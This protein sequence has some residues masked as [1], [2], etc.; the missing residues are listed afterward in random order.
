ME[1]L[2]QTPSQTVGPFFAYSLT[3]E[4]YGYDYNS[5]ING[6]LINHDT[7]GERI[8]ITGRIY[9]GK[10]QTIPDALIELWQADANGQY[11]SLPIHQKN[12]GFTGLGRLGTGTDVQDRF[13]FT[14]IK[15]GSIG[16]GQA[17]HINIILFMRG[18][19][20]RLYTRLYF[21]DESATNSQDELFNTIPEERRNTLIAQRKQNAGRIEYHFDIY[22][23]GEKETVFLMY[24]TNDVIS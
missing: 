13:L 17:P 5:L 10:G 24:I 2:R 11:R 20:H 8:Y 3:A 7:E 21:S 15:P 6:L 9:D 12:D 19:L 23:Q 18:S 22:M 4:Q 14:T 16:D 1:K